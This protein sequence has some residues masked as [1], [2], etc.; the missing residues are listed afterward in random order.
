M[1]NP[2]NWIRITPRIQALVIKAIRKV[3]SKRY[4]GQ[5]LGSLAQ[6][7][8]HLIN[9][10]LKQHQRHIHIKRYERLLTILEYSEKWGLNP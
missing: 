5:R 4:L 10:I 2:Q 7:P 1:L 8:E 3:G 9:N 6:H